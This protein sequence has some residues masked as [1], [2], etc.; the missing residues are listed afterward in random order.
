MKACFVN[1]VPEMRGPVKGITIRL[2]VEVRS[3]MCF[4]YLATT[5]RDLKSDARSHFIDPST[6]GQACISSLKQ[7]YK[8]LVDL[9]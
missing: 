7:F 4:S 5:Q 9:Q 8:E 1:L 2:A 6:Y 3:Q